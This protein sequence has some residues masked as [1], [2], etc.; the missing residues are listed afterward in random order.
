MELLSTI[1]VIT[2]HDKNIRDL[3]TYKDVGAMDALCDYLDN[4][5]LCVFTMKEED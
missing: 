5:Y 2:F 3:F 4:V 1:R